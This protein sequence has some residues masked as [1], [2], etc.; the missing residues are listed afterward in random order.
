M[1][2][3][4]CIFR[5][6]ERVGEASVCLFTA[7]LMPT[8]RSE[9]GRRSQEG[10]V[11]GECLWMHFSM[12]ALKNSVAP[13]ASSSSAN[14][15]VAGGTSMSA[16]LSSCSRKRGSWTAALAV[17]GDATCDTTRALSPRLLWVDFALCTFLLVCSV[18]P[19]LRPLLSAALLPFSGFRLV[20]TGT[21]AAA[22]GFFQPS[23]KG[24][25]KPAE[26]MMGGLPRRHWDAIVWTLLR[27]ASRSC[28]SWS[29]TM[30][31]GLVS[32]PPKSSPRLRCG[33]IVGGTTTEV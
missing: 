30:L 9:S 10:F 14:G 21:T 33:C 5:E 26:R 27:L 2:A 6:R 24:P 8:L 18:L 17:S 20:R 16:R 4:E 19:L 11:K 12:L 23:P 25:L 3:C 32:K 28:G 7:K 22:Q 1:L 15:A 13:D 29:S 31:S